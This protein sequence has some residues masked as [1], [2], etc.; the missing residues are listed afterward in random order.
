MPAD[1][2]V[3]D[4]H[5]RHPDHDDQRWALIADIVARVGDALAAGNWDTDEGYP[6]QGFVTVDGYP[7]D[8]TSTEQE[9]VSGWF[10]IAEPVRFDPWFEPLTSGRHRLWGTMPHFGTRLVP[11]KSDVLDYVT[12]E[13]VPLLGKDWHQ[14]YVANVEELDSLP[15][16]D[17]RDPL[18]VAF[19]SA[20]VTAASRQFPSPQ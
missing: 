15:W 19:R 11:I 1:P 2:D 12:P 20:L 18:N 6:G 14:M 4:G 10:G 13:S 17:A 9:I 8:L 7:G 3:E 5:V 16:F